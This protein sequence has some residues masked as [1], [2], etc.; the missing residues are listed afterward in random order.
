MLG[1]RYTRQEVA[2]LLD[3]SVRTLEKW[4]ERDYGPPFYRF[5]R[6]VYYPHDEL[7][8]W[9]QKMKARRSGDLSE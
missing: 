9:V 6:H 1:K 2:S 8:A 3:L 5:G 4:K 7:M